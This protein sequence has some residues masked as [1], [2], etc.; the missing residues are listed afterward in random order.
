M[1]H[2]AMT[3]WSWAELAPVVPEI[4]LA[5]AAMG[6]LML[7]VFRGDSHTRE[8]MTLAVVALALAAVLLVALPEAGLGAAEA[9]T[10]LSGLFV[11]DAFAVY[12][13]LL[14]LLSAGVAI[15]LSF[16]FLEARQM[17][18]IEFPV[19]VL[20]A[21]LGM[22]VMIS[23]GDLLTLYLGAELQSLALYVL[24]SFRRDNAR[25]AEAGLKYFILG[26]LSSAFILYGIS[27]T[28]GFAG[29]TSF[30]P[31]GE[32]L[33]GALDP[34]GGSFIGI[35]FG[36]TF[37]TV[38]LAFKISAAPFHMW[39]PDVYEGAPTPVTAFFAMAPKVAAVA[40][41]LRLLID[42][43]GDLTDQWRQLIVPLAVLSLIVGAYGAI[44][45]TN[46][47]RFMAYSSIGHMGVVLV[48][49]AAGTNAAVQAIA[50]YMAIYVVMSAGAFAVILCMRQQGRNVENIHDL[51]GLSHSHP[52][53]AAAMGILMFSLA[54]IPPLGGF[55]GKFYVFLAAVHAGLTWLAVVGVLMAVVSAF[56]YL[57]IVKIIYF[58][59]PGEPLDRP[60]P[61]ELGATALVSA[62]LTLG[63][64][65]V[66]APVLEHA[67]RAAAS[68]DYYEE[69]DSG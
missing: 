35:L 65:L 59:P 48:G 22:M 47:K 31:L 54:G 7:G 18:R 33:Y 69:S 63:F 23:A 68:F 56:Y 44:A 58:D 1:M 40:L 52:G 30:A 10:T 2:A 57:R 66:A 24:A 55:F 34:A 20:F 50:F 53:L 51:A 26:A 27:L 25:S 17:A 28:Y 14:V 61:R 36:L 8:I 49:L 9:G 62:A 37:L 12:M 46:I 39:T 45:Q 21:S 4:W 43:F 29:T 11:G 38:G 32:I 16:S 15:L 19:L 6:L 64:F 41:I 5:L 13:K 60:I 3:Q 67:A 42:P